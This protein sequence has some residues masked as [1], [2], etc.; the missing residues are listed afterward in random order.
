MVY[1]MSI[2]DKMCVPCHYIYENTNHVNKK[3]TWSDANYN[4]KNVN[5]I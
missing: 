2:A 4:M 1:R 3:K 5:N